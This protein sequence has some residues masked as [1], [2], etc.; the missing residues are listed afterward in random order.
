MGYFRTFIAI[1]TSPSALLTLHKTGALRAWLRTLLTA[2][3]CGVLFAVLSGFTIYP[4]LRECARFFDRAF[5]G[6]RITRAAVT[7]VE[8]PDTIRNCALGDAAVLTWLPP[9]A[10][11]PMD[12][13]SGDLASGALWTADALIMWQRLK[14]G[15]ISAAMMSFDTAGDREFFS[16]PDREFPTRAAAAIA[17]SAVK[18]SA[19]A[20]DEARDFT[21]LDIVKVWSVILFPGAALLMTFWIFFI[22]NFFCGIFLGMNRLF[23]GRNNRL[24]AS[25]MWTVLLYTGYP[26]MAVGTVAAGLGLDISYSTVYIFGLVIYLFFVMVRFE[27]AFR[28][29]DPG[30][31][32]RDGGE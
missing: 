18:S 26:A 25:E 16:C 4:R 7:P 29:A 30:P 1:C 22:A 3:F 12:Y 2:F 19:S 8:A 24:S 21:A 14:P 32:K 31:M 23:Y 9:D 5:G 10:A 17:R 15:E 13:P 20:G 6:V 27:R 11:L 28:G